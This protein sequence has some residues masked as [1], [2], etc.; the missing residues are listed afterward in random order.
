MCWFHAESH[1]IN[2]Q[3]AV[4]CILAAKALASTGEA[5]L[6]GIHQP[7][8]HASL[9]LRVLRACHYEF[10]SYFE[11]LVRSFGISLHPF[12]SRLV[13]PARSF[14]FSLV[15]R[16]SCTRHSSFARFSVLFLVTQASVCSVIRPYAQRIVP[17]NLAIIHR[18]RWPQLSAALWR[19]ILMFTRLHG[20]TLPAQHWDILCHHTRP[21]MQRIC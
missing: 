14:D 2:A 9:F 15:L 18:C 13:L 21:R 11:F 3:H 8:L 10:L 4:L 16:R 12:H 19:L 1:F 7:K 5:A 17:F 20:G 6:T